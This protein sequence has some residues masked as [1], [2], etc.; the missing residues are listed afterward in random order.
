ML[1]PYLVLGLPLSATTEEIRRRYLELVRAH[2]PGRHPARF[3]RITA[4]YEALKEDRARV[5]T[6][7][8]GMAGYGDFEL[9]LDALVDARPDRRRAPGLQALLAAEGKPH[10]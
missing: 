10:A 9:A 8:F 3:E 6:A 4:A 7:L 2:R 1:A 5:R